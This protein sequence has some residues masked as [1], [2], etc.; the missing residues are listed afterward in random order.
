MAGT[1][2]GHLELSA[3]AH[4]KRRNVKV[5]QPGL[6]YVI[7]WN[8]G[9]VDSLPT[10]VEDEPIDET[11]LNERDK[12]RLRRDRKKQEKEKAAEVVEQGSTVYVA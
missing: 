4:L 1:Y 10:V 11:G 3:F 2:G 12:R 9:G 7:E 5:I 6:V 8:I